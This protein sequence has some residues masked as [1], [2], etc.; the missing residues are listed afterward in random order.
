MKI[1]KIF[2]EIANNYQKEFQYGHDS[3]RVF[4]K[5]KEKKQKQNTHC[6]TQEKQ[7]LKE[8]THTKP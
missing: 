3:C 7:K 2:L 1:E 5:Y 8:N 6:H 4:Y